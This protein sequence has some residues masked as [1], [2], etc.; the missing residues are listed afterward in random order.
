MGLFWQNEAKNAAISEGAIRAEVIVEK[1]Q[2]RMEFDA[3]GQMPGADCIFL[4]ER[5]Q[6]WFRVAVTLCWTAM[7]GSGGT[8]TFRS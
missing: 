5:T 4:A 6:F 3:L 8:A 7:S 2:T 1:R